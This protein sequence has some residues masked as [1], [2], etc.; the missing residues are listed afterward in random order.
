[1]KTLSLV[2]LITGLS[3]LQNAISHAVLKKTPRKI[4]HNFH[5]THSCSLMQSGEN[6]TLCP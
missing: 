5:T 2:L 1:M 3:Q 4:M 6:L